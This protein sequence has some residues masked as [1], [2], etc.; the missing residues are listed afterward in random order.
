ML[1]SWIV[2]LSAPCLPENSS[3]ETMWW[4]V[5]APHGRPQ[6]FPR[7][8][9]PIWENTQRVVL[10]MFAKMW[11]SP[12]APSIAAPGHKKSE[13]M[14]RTWWG[15]VK[16]TPCFPFY[17]FYTLLVFLQAVFEV[18]KIICRLCKIDVYK[19]AKDLVNPTKT[20]GQ[21]TSISSFWKMQRWINM[22][23]GLSGFW[24]LQIHNSKF[25]DFLLDVW[26][27]ISPS[28]TKL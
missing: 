25:Q 18:R 6:N 27:L 4:I 1:N 13:E 16:S 22:D 8:I 28:G 24:S 19:Y 23:F 26:K 5:S 7:H 14:M 12:Q 17:I 9:M 3:T 21:H 15:N 20:N 2:R 11:G 10:W